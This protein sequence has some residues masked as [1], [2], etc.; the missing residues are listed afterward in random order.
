MYGIED[1][2]IGIHFIY[3]LC[4]QS[5]LAS[6]TRE[7][8]FNLFFFVINF[9]KYLKNTHDDLIRTVIKIDKMKEK[10]YVLPFYSLNT[11]RVLICSK[12][13]ANIETLFTYRMNGTE[14]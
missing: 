2:G 11:L 9:C 6:R 7:L 1:F 10:K 14:V 8:Y 5:L 4:A 12:K 3:D 13:N